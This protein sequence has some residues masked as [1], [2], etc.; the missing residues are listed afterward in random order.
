MTVAVQVRRRL[1]GAA[2][3]SLLVGGPGRALVL[4]VTHLR[5]GN[6]VELR[7]AL[8][9]AGRLRSRTLGLL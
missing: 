9:A 5:A 2:R 6:A 7:R 8:L 1:S 3:L 4:G